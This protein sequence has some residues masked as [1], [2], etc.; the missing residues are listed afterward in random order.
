MV[1]SSTGPSST[2][3]EPSSGPPTPYAESKAGEKTGLTPDRASTPNIV[4][5]GV[6]LDLG[7]GYITVPAIRVLEGM[8]REELK[9]VRDFQLSR[10]GMG[11]VSWQEP[12][13]LTDVKLSKAVR[14]YENQGGWPEV[15]VHED[16][17]EDKVPEGQKLN[18]RAL[19]TLQNY[20]ARKEW[21]VEKQ[22]SFGKHLKA[23][24]ERNGATFCNYDANSGEWQFFV[25]HFSRWGFD[26]SFY[27]EIGEVEN[28]DSPASHKFT[29][30][31]NFQGSIENAEMV[32]VS[33]HN[34]TNISVAGNNPAP[35]PAHS[36][37]PNPQS[38]DRRYHTGASRVSKS[39]NFNHN[40][41]S[42]LIA[43]ASDDTVSHH[44][45]AS[46]LGKA[47]SRSA[48]AG[49]RTPAPSF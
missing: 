16:D 32:V 2:R 33:D 29:K 13:D 6:D 27:E 14:F 21:S 23:Y 5:G 40:V 15:S 24:N 49:G 25:P 8:S 18:R 17:T 43:P 9:S 31:L 10:P 26:D 45:F 19:V 36:I 39:L 41:T 3:S 22:A 11:S 44:T 38:R 46:P 48:A 4:E 20:F 7:D 12:V 47:S 35:A 30:H 37:D 28:K 34:T 1:E 42:S